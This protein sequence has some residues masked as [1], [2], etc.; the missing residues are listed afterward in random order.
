MTEIIELN[1]Y[2]TNCKHNETLKTH[3]IVDLAS[4]I[5]PT[6]KQ[7]MKISMKNRYEE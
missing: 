6:C 5:C 1:C 3:G 7:P 4:V 2:C